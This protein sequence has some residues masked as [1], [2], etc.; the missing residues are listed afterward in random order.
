MLSILETTFECLECRQWKEIR[1]GTLED[2]HRLCSPIAMMCH[3]CSELTYDI[4]TVMVW[5]V[6]SFG[7]LLESCNLAV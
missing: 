3:G 7:W 2:K 6:E 5:T 1:R 4:Q